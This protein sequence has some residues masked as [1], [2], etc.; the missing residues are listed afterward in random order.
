M[1]QSPVQ[2]LSFLGPLLVGTDH[3]KPGTP[4]Q[5]LPFWRCSVWPSLPSQF[6]PYSRRSNPS[7]C[8]SF[9]L[10]THR[11]QDLTTHLLPCV[12]HPLTPLVR[13]L[14]DDEMMMLFTSPVSGFN[15]VADQCIF[16]HFY[17]F[18][19]HFNFFFWTPRW[20]V[21]FEIFHFLKNGTLMPRKASGFTFIRTIS[22]WMTRRK[23]KL[24][25]ILYMELQLG[26]SSYESLCRSI[27][28]FTDNV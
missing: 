10:P 14:W 19:L 17:I 12:S 18:C 15:V 9:M 23:G 20:N 16:L 3:Y 28:C 13:W 26:V 22:Y 27:M 7:T 4:P 1:T 2:Q 6:G 24:L 25:L 5:D 21:L 8:P 11:L